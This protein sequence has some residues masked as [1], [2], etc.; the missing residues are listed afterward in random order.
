MTVY[1]K[2]KTIRLG[3]ALLMIWLA[4]WANAQGRA[5]RLYECAS[6][7]AYQD[8]IT[9][10]L[11]SN[12]FTIDRPI[13]GQDGLVSSYEELFGPAFKHRILKNGQR[14]LDSGAGRGRSGLEFFDIDA[15]VYVEPTGFF[16]RHYG[17]VFT[18]NIIDPN[19]QIQNAKP[20]DDIMDAMGPFSYLVDK[21][22]T[23]VGP[24][25]SNAK[26][27]RSAI[28]SYLELIYKKLK[29]GGHFHSAFDA[30]ILDRDEN[31]VPVI[32]SAGNMVVKPGFRVVDE[33][34]ADVTERWFR[35]IKGLK[36]VSDIQ[37]LSQ[38]FQSKGFHKTRFEEVND[39][40]SL[41]LLRTSEELFIPEIEQ[42]YSEDGRP[43]IR[44]FRLVSP[45]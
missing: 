15:A 26:K 3:C 14:V 21:K 22:N 28:L 23:N 42:I 33:H 40:R 36:L 17:R 29:V 43:P 25:R 41:T 19:N 5:S 13:F 8:K 20:Y 39:T 38:R 11:M 34:G 1:F 6:I 31:R 44:I 7:Y 16:H 32:D 18:G 9:A 12:D 30:W 10:R 35:S 37:M 45:H 27:E 24:L 4:P 2:L